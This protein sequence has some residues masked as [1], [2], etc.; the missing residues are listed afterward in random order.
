MAVETRSKLLSLVACVSILSLVL[1]GLTGCGKEEN[2]A[3]DANAAAAM[4]ASGTGQASVDPMD[5]ASTLFREPTPDL[6][7]IVDAAKTWSPSLQDWWGKVAP[8]FTLNDI[9]G[10]SHSLSEYRGKNVVVVIWTTWIATCKLQTPHLKDLRSAYKDADLAVLA[11]SNESPALLKEAVAEQ[12]INFTM[13]A[14]GANLPAPFGE[15]KYA[16]AS[17]FIDPRG[18]FKLISSGLVPVGDAKA[19]VQAR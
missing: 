18:R 9:D 12:G 14:G 6:Q 17:F 7:Y 5:A 1:G 11:I 2:P 19:I 4:P 8:D 13:L 16:P 3:E 10:H 15:V